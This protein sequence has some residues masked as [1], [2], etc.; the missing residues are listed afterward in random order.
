MTDHK[1]TYVYM[2]TKACQPLWGKFI[3]AHG[4]TQESLRPELESPQ[5]AQTPWKS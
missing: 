1:Y 4:Q 3:A 2:P 5:I